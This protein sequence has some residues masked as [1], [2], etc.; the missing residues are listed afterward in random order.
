VVPAARRREQFRTKV[1]VL[2][3]AFLARS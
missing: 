1:D 3:A 2:Q